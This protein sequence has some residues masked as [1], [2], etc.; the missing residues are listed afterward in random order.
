M[1]IVHL[2]C[3]APPETGGIGQ[4]AWEMVRRLRAFGEDAVLL[5]RDVPH[6]GTLPPDPVGVIR[7]PSWLRYGN[8]AALQGV[9]PYIAT[10]DVVHL[11]YPFFG[12]AE[13]VAQECVLRQKPLILTF[14]MDATA[15][16][17]FGLLFSAYRALA[18]PALL[19]AAKRILVSSMDYARASSLHGVTE[20]YPHRV[21]ELPFGVDHTFFT[22]GAGSRAAFSLPDDVPVIGFVGGMDAP[23]AFKGIRVLLDALVR[24]PGAHA[25]LVGEGPLRRVYE[26]RV[27][28]LGIGARCHFVGRIP[29]E[30]LPDAYRAM[31]VLAFPS[32]SSA[33]AFGLVA[34]EA[35]ACG[36]PVVA[37]N[38][39][40]V[41]SVVADGVTGVL[42]PPRNADA[43]ADALRGLIQDEALRTAYGRAARERVLARYDWDRHIQQLT[44]VYQEVR[45]PRLS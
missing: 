32:T 8:A 18:Q 13:H 37:S 14:H 22:P 5:S 43:L 27:R 12:T 42:A 26:A 7:L 21:I 33:E 16:L 28:E 40:G 19:R 39:A 31:D 44:K 24:I 6:R 9:T 38:L 25:L 11:H 10:A 35:M 20:R 17:P 41:R 1:R 36:V 23:H 2:A 45:A 3:L 34:I 15:P 4:S 30:Q 29:Q